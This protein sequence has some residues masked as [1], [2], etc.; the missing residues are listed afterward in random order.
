MKRCAGLAVCVLVTSAMGVVLSAC[1]RGAAE[2][3]D[4]SYQID[5]TRMVFERLK[6]ALDEHNLAPDS[7]AAAMLNALRRNCVVMLP[8]LVKQKAPAG[9]KEMLQTKADQ[10]R[11][12]FESQ[13]REPLVNGDPP[14]FEGA[15]EAVDKCLAILDE[16]AAV[17]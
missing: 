8:R 6:P 5:T 16:M 9:K 2:R 14:D 3:S 11:D 10:L 12:T 17:R 4:L 7:T 1:D 15:K 13:I